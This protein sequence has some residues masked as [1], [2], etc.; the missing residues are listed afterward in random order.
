MAG[1]PS[2]LDTLNHG[3]KIDVGHLR[4]EDVHRGAEFAWHL[5]EHATHRVGNRQTALKG[6]VTAQD[7]FS[8]S[9]R[10]CA[11]TLR[12]LLEVRQDPPKLVVRQR[13]E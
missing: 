2:L 13:G 6:R 5:L 8:T 7:L 1:F 11:A 4:Q 3:G 12:L 10:S 9:I